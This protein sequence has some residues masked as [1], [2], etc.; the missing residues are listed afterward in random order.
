MPIAITYDGSTYAVMMATPADLEDFALGFSLTEGVIDSPADIESLETVELD[1]GIKRG[2]G[3]SR[4]F[5]RGNVPG[6]EASLAQP[7]A[8]SAGRKA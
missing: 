2:F 5:P 8:A 6:A 1:D 3:L 7:A 4:R